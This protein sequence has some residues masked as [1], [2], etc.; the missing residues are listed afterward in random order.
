MGDVS[1]GVGTRIQVLTPGVP[2]NSFYVYQHIREN[3]KPIYKDVNG[4]RVDGVPNGTINEQDLYVDQNG[5][6]V[7]NQGDLRPVPRPG[8]EMDS[9]PLV[10]LCPGP[11]RSRLYR[12]VVSGQLHLQQ[13]GL[14]QRRLPRAHPGLAL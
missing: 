14:R 13:R 7:I 2:V 8:A 12:P 11:V 1:G 6:G 3:G 10:V 4:D 9:R 5:D